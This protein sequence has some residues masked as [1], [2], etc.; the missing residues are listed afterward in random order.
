MSSHSYFISHTKFRNTSLTG[1]FRGIGAYARS[2]LI[3]CGGPNVYDTC[4]MFISLIAWVGLQC[5]I[6][7]FPGHTHLLYCC[8][9]LEVKLYEPQYRIFNNVVCATSKCS[10]QPANTHSLITAFASRLNTTLVLSY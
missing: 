3:S 4:N 2:T 8:I 7:V 9:K 6:M 5:V 10:D 1:H